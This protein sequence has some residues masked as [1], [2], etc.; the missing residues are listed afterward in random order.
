MKE[1]VNQCCF[2]IYSHSP[3]AIYTSYWALPW[4]GYPLLRVIICAS[5]KGGKLALQAEGLYSFLP[6][7]WDFHCR[8]MGMNFLE[9][10]LLPPP[11]K[12]LCSQGCATLKV[13]CTLVWAPSLECIRAAQELKREWQCHVVLVP[14]SMRSDDALLHCL[15]VYQHVL[16]HNHCLM[17]NCS[18][19][20]GPSTQW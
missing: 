8:R 15:L 9:T 10:T 18:D 19:K 3:T 11:T 4:A 7:I 12:A 13:T 14:T 2:F 20:K 6:S 1:W 5:T 17:N 16:D